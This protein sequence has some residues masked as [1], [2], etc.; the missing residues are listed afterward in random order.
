[1]PARGQLVCSANQSRPD[2]FGQPRLPAIQVKVAKIYLGTPKAHWPT[3]N[4]D[5]EAERNRYEAEFA[6]MGKEFADVDFVTNHLVTKT[7]DLAGLR[8]K[9]QAA[10]GVLIIH[11]SMH[12]GPV[13]KEIL[14][15]KK[16]TMVFAAPYSGH[17]WAGFGAA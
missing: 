17:E 14:A 3:P 15:A 8:D 4:M 12:V 5:I 2:D 16:P 9:L 13:L 6:R 7:E 11:L 10:D 1:M